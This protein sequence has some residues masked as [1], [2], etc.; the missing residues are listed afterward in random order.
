MALDAFWA[1]EQRQLAAASSTG[2]TGSST[3]K[4]L[5]SELKQKACELAYDI[6]AAN[7]DDPEQLTFV[8]K[9]YLY[10]RSASIYS[11]TS[12]VHHNILAREL[13]KGAV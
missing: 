2:A 13:L 10:S 1:F 12:E 7:I 3:L 8:T 11:G 6:G 4:L 9:R 5:G